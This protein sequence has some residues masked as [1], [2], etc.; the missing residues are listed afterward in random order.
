MTLHQPIAVNSALHHTMQQWRRD[1]HQ[2]PETAYEEFRTSQKVAEQLKVLGLAV[3]ENIG[4]TGVVGVLKGKQGI[5]RHIGLRADMD[6]LPL[7]ELNTFEH[8]SCHHG[9]MHGCGHDGHTTMLLG[10]ATYLAQH[11]DFKGTV[12]FIFQPA[13][14]GFAGAK[15]MIEDG[16]F[17]RFPIEEVYGMHNWPDLP[18]GQLG[19]HTGAVMAS[20]DSFYITVTGKGGH[21]AIPDGVIDPIVVTGQLILAIQ[22]IVSRNISPLKSGVVSITQVHGGSATNIIPEEVKL[23]GTIRTLDENQ[24]ALIKERL[25]Q[26]VTQTAHA[27]GAH[28]SLEIKPMYPV[29]QNTEREAEYCYE[30]A[31][32]LVGESNAIWNPLPS[33]AAE[34][35]SFMLQQRPGAYI[36]LGN[37]AS[38]HNKPLHNPYYDFN[39][40][41]LP[42]GASFWV[43]LVEQRCC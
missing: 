42:L 18:A 33:M 10:A 35:F 12:Y 23:S 22:S 21:A 7:L 34:D 28:A 37:G 29:T 41:V 1:I 31:K 38:T 6:A 32:S 30:A 8:K 40:G 5:G 2:H 43:C 24:R 11:N 4:G 19:I 15:R 13:E 9:K 27:F 16:L 25:E 14:E 17:T 36:W 26:I 3:Y 39:D 20:T